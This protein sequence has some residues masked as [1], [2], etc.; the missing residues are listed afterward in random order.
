MARD[1]RRVLHVILSCIS[2]FSGRHGNTYQCPFMVATLIDWNLALPRAPT[3]R[4]S[5]A[6]SR[7]FCRHTS[8]WPTR[9]TPPAASTVQL[10]IHRRSA[11]LPCHLNL[12]HRL[13]PCRPESPLWP[14][15]TRNTDPPPPQPRILR[16][17]PE[18][19]SGDERKM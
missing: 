18:F 10:W 3:D 12:L 1:H 9:L 15:D 11:A 4:A 19:A 16:R 6:L 7:R 14:M 5:A 2:S 17:S 13:L 8:S